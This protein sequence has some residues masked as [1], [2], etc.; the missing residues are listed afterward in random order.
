MEFTFEIE[1]TTEVKV[2]YD[3]LVIPDQVDVEDLE[4]SSFLG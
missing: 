2:P 4:R 1:M 3:N